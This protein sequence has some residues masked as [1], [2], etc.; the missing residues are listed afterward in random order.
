VTGPAPGAAGTLDG[1]LETALTSPSGLGPAALQEILRGA[2]PGNADAWGSTLA[3]ILY[4]RADLANREL[5]EWLG[6]LLGAASLSERAASVAIAALE[7]LARTDLGASVARTAMDLLSRNESPGSAGRLV[8]LL[9]ACVSWCPEHLDVDA[10]IDGAGRPAVEG[11][12]DALLGH[13]VEPLIARAAERLTESTLDRLEEAF[14]GC[15]RRPYTLALIGD[16]SG[17]SRPVQARAAARAGSMF[18]ARAAARA[19][20]VDRAFDLLVVLNVRLGQGDEIVRLGALFQA[21]LDANPALRCTVITRRTYLYDHPRVRTASIRDDAATGAALALPYD[22]VMHVREPGWPEVAWSSW[23][24]AR[25]EALI[26]ERPPAFTITGRIGWNHF[27]YDSV[28]LGG[29][30]L[31]GARRLDR[32]G[33]Q[34]IYDGCQRLLAELGLPTRIGEEAPATPSPYTG[35]PSADADRI[36]TQMT[37]PVTRPIALVCPYGGAHR[38]KGYPE[39]RTDRLVGEIAA[40]VAEGYGVVLLPNGTAWGSGTATAASW[41]ASPR[42]SAAAW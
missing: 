29:R 27:V 4:A 14:A 30:E 15:A 32:L 26:A 18:P 19:L 13:V 16:R 12:R 33:A 34:N 1:L 5:V 2:E 22:G 42:A 35:A 7:A 17:A 11:Q 31:A 10:V 25:V 41:T 36:W 6:R 40:L 38:I 21:L 37:A 23:L 3:A 9:R 28:M 24:D 39:E 8:A 20:L